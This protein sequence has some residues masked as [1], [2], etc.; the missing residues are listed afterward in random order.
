VD[1]QLGKFLA[2]MQVPFPELTELVFSSNG[3]TLPVIP[4]S[5]LGGSAP[6][7]RHFELDGIPFPGLPNMLM[8]ATHLVCLR[9]SNIPQSGYIS[10]E[11][12]VALLSVLSSLNFLELEFQF[13]QSRP[14]WET[15]RPHPAKRSVI[16]ALDVFRF[17]GVIE[18]LEDLVTFIDAP[19]LNRLYVTSFNQMVFDTPRLTQ[20]INC[21]PT[22]REFDVANM[23]FDGSTA[24]VELQHRTFCDFRI[25]ISCPEPDRQLSSVAR[26]C[27][28]FLPPLSMVE[29]LY[30]EQEC[31]QPIWENVAIE[32]TLWLELLLAFAAVKNLYLSK[33]F[34]PDIA[35]ALQ[36][37]VGARITKELPSLQ[38]IFV[39]KL[40]VEPSGSLQEN[41]WQFAGARRQSGHPITISDWDRD[42]ELKSM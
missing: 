14:D 13:P 27:N 33:E 37:L 34:A 24:G 29:D 22:L 7:L 19:Q 40:R 6:R 8:S 11:A 28:S 15:R 16:P 36:E 26:V 30:I 20:F 3:E 2:A 35:S 23:Y 1:W 17:K 39:E 38:N 9:L 25:E 5:F 21:T 18:Y 31:S 42:S 10:P 12:M 4:D 41:I 32:N